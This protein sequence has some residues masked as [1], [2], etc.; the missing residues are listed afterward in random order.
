MHTLPN[1]GNGPA[2]NRDQSPARAKTGAKSTKR[3]TAASAGF[4]G[5]FPWPNC[6]PSGAG[7]KSL[8]ASSAERESDPRLGR[9]L[10]RARRKWPAAKSEAI[11]GTAEEWRNVDCALRR[12]GRGLAGG[13][14]LAK[15]LS[16]RRGAPNPACRPKL[17]EAKILAWAHRFFLK[18]GRWPSVQSGPIL[19]SPG[20]TWQSV[21]QALSKGCRGL[22]G[23]SSLAKLLR[24]RDFES[25]L[26]R[27]NRE[28]AQEPVCP[29][30]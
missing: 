22:R 27:L 14:S 23:G 16:Q 28:R 9:R 26:L 13:S 12:G 21:N 5:V 2:R 11:T 25:R 6:W 18:E 20:D 29:T 30:S 10:F 24:E 4:R 15:L 7:A 17:S 8:G 19:Q 1:T 3:C